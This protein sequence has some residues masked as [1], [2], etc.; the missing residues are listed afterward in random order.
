MW[1]L[2][3]DVRNFVTAPENLKVIEKMQ[4]VL[5]DLGLWVPSASPSACR[6]RSERYPDRERRL[7]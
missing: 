3:E 6:A 1:S 5:E 4:K 7:E 2:V